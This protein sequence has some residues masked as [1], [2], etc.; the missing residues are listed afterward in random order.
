MQ[1]LFDTL[2][3]NSRIIVY[4][5][6]IAFVISG[7]FMGY[8]AYLNNQGG[9][10]NPNQRPNVIAEVNGKEISQQEYFSLL[11]QQ[12]PQSNLSSSQIIPFRYSVLNALI[13]RKLILSQAEKMDIQ[14]EV[15][16]A[17]IDQR[18]NNI[19]K[20][21][22]LD[23][24]ELAD[25]LAE[26]GFT[27]GDLRDD[28]KSSLKDS[29]L[30]TETIDQGI[31]QIEISEEEIKDLYAQRYPAEDSKQEANTKKETAADADPKIEAE[32]G[33][34]NTENDSAG[35]KRP[36][37]EEVKSELETELK[38][39]K[40]NQAVNQW[41]KTLKSEAEI[42]VND[43]VLSAYHAL[44]KENYDSA[45]EQFQSFV[46]SEQTDPIFYNYLAQ[47]YQGQNNY[48]KAE[49]VYQNAVENYPENIDLKFSYS[50]YLLE[51]E[52]NEDAAAQL[53]EIASL[54]QDNFMTH[55][56]LF[57]LYNQLGK[58]E[59][60]QAALE[61]IQEISKKMQSSSD[62]AVSENMDAIEEEA[63]DLNSDVEIESKLENENN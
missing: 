59:E 20:Q 58:E 10:Q 61:K 34:E 47:A 7:G 9:A 42:T 36:A 32:A 31:A 17:E 46:D 52:K 30:I 55:Y 51:Q 60:A 21:S 41:L 23:D 2:R 50:R 62:S 57:M 45:V 4:L 53:D 8:G 18:Y 3:D 5:V 12:A 22:N 29:K 39:R 1:V 26:Q 15:S 40:K 49:E 6:V 28:I 54:A 11:Q 38:N 48:Q 35:E 56:Q 33:K 25:N 13:E 14:V 16:E 63:E 27:I 44:E 37:L 24:Q 43:P 19:L